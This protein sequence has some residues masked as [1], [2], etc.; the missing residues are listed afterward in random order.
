MDESRDIKLDRA[1]F[2][3]RAIGAIHEAV[4]R[5][6]VAMVWLYRVTLGPVMGGHCL[7]QPTCSQYMIDA[8]RKYG[9][10]PGVWRGV[11]RLCRCHP[12]GRGGHDPA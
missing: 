5:A 11:K 7:Y 1:G 12:W 4:V 2:L 6:I 9:A 8:V 3:R 10:L